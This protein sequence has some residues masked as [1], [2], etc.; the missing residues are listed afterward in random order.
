MAKF[1]CLDHKRTSAKQPM[2][3]PLEPDIANRKELSESPGWENDL[4]EA[5][6][7]EKQQR[8]AMQRAMSQLGENCRQLFRTMLE[9]GLEKPRELFGRLGLQ[10][11]RAVTVLRYECTKQLKVKAAVELELLMQEGH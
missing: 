4:R 8:E 6:Q 2:T 10:D 7:R 11:A 3:T 9:T 1:M 5:A